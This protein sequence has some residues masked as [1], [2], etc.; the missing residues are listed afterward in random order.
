MSGVI[1]EKPPRGKTVGDLSH[2]HRGDV[3]ERLQQLAR[4]ASA[5]DGF[6]RRSFP[7][8]LESFESGCG[9]LRIDLSNGVIAEQRLPAGADRSEWLRVCE[10]MLLAVRVDG[11]AR[12]RFLKSAG[13]RSDG[14]RLTALA[15]PVGQGHRLGNGVLVLFAHCRD[16]EDAT[17]QLADLK[18]VA[19]LIDALAALVA[20][21]NARSAEFQQE[22]GSAARAGSFESFP[23]FVFA[24]VNNLKNKLGCERVYFGRMRGNRISVAGISGFDQLYPRS[25]S[26]HRVAQA[27][28]ECADH[29][30][31]I[32]RQTDGRNR[33]EKPADFRLH[34]QWRESLG[35][36]SVASIP[37]MH[38]D[39]CIAVVSLTNNPDRRFS[40]EQLRKAQKLLQPL[41]STLLLLER[42]DRSLGRH[43]LEEARTAI[44]ALFGR[45]AWGRKLATAAVLIVAAWMILGTQ[46]YHVTVPCEIVSA[47]TCSLAAPFQG[48]LA[49]ADFLP[50]DR[51][52]AG[53]VLARLDTTELETERRRLYAEREIARLELTQAVREQRLAEA[54]QARARIAMTDSRLEA[55]AWKIERAV[56]RAPASGTILRGDLQ[57]RVGDV[58]ELGEPLFELAVGDRWSVKLHLPEFVVAHFRGR[59]RGTFT[60]QARPDQPYGLQVVH[61][62]ASAQ[63]VDGKTVV[64]ADGRV[65]G[66]PPQWIRSGMRGVARIDT[67]RYPVWWVY[68]HGILDRIRYQWWKL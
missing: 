40:D 25:R 60:M 62:E 63:V 19:A 23:Q 56:I 59:E 41:A 52:T 44:R 36:A 58:V 24:L 20:R 68:G 2:A 31:V 45:G 13:E 39:R 66:K 54:A 33:R 53:T 65:D 28:E 8:V 61:I 3:A 4:E 9:S 34:R 1:A 29:R 17:R 6:Y 43:L 18:T 11:T 32:V 14:R 5:V 57:S 38:E 48:T 21:R 67:G 10:A 30:E 37:I 50:G 42:A 46:H 26:V 12:A 49:S 15:V 16:S 55:I 27:M 22:A 35:G 47:E 7:V 64:L 51:V